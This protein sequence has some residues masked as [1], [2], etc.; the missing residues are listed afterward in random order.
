MVGIIIHKWRLNM[1]FI[2]F[3]CS[4][5][6]AFR[7]SCDIQVRPLTLFFGKNNSGKSSLLRLPRLLL[8]TLSARVRNGFPVKVDG[9]D[10]AGSFRELSHGGLTHGAASFGIA[11]ENQE[12]FLDMKATV[13]SVQNPFSIAGQPTELS[14]VAH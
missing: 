4:N 12:E 8:R 14:V 3:S 6:K 9:L 10:F 11:L 13:Q 7:E 5:Y 2:S 1:K